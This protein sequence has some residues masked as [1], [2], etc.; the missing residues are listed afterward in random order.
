M[1]M[2]SLIIADESFYLNAG[3]IELLQRA[4][5]DVDVLSVDQSHSKYPGIK[6]FILAKSTLSIS[7][8]AYS[9]RG[10]YNLIV[11]G[12]D[13]ILLLIKETN[14]GLRGKV[15]I[16]PVTNSRYIHH[17]CSKI[18]L[19]KILS[20]NNILTPAYRICERFENLPELIFELGYPSILKIDFS[21][22]GYGCFEI[23]SKEDIKNIPANF[24]NK[25]LLVQKMIEG[26][27][28]DASAFY[29]DKKLVHFSFSESLKTKDHKFGVSVLRK[30]YQIGSLDKG[31]FDDLKLLG[32]ALGAN[33]FVNIGIIESS[34]D[35]RRYFFEA[36]M[37]P[38]A[39]VNFS[40]YIG[41]DAAIKIKEYFKSRK[42]CS[43]PYK[44]NKAFPT[45]EILAFAPRLKLWEILL[46]RY[47]CLGYI[48][49]RLMFLEC[50]MM[51]PKSCARA[52]AIKYLKP[53]IP[54]TLWL[55]LK[56][57]FNYQ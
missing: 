34:I 7:N 46:N 18:E 15:K 22:G 17:L 24:R 39:W 38:N 40:S 28:I 11:P 44:S 30:Y 4:R 10:Q 23:R 57:Y 35:G 52:L 48:N 37:R 12:G 53:I 16:L 9:L 6:N 21:G 47:N 32:E 5:F 20:A 29:Q 19:S 43:Y 25:R 51:T 33:G 3:V 36:D 41:D 2:K 56:G 45:F 13:R 54:G 26:K 27:I 31:I 14:L 8:E 55:K 50:R 49:W 42:I 1:G